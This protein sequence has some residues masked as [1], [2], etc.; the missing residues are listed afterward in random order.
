MRTCLP[1]QQL[2]FRPLHC[3]ESGFSGV[4]L[5][6]TTT[7]MPPAW[8]DIAIAYSHYEQSTLADD[9]LTDGIGTCRASGTRVPHTTAACNR[10]QGGPVLTT[11]LSVTHSHAERSVRIMMHCNVQ[12]SI[13]R[14][15]SVHERGSRRRQVTDAHTLLTLSALN[16]DARMMDN[17]HMSLFGILQPYSI[18]N[19]V[20][21]P[22][23]IVSYK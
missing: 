11:Q 10:T 14:M 12:G 3:R 1:S 7:Y 5:I 17:V 13:R 20:W 6:L 18:D 15:G 4:I 22:Q 19:D 16:S 8:A 9:T 2:K 23:T 21:F